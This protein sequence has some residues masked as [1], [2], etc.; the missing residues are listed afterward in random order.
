[1]HW[2]P[3]H[4]TGR[5]APTSSVDVDL[6]SVP[7]G[8]GIYGQEDRSVDF[9]VG[10]AL[11]YKVNAQTHQMQVFSNGKLLRTHP[12]HHRQAGLHHPLRASR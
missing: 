1:M 5:P 9:H 10:D 4:A 12:D 2:R 8:N 3:K 7:A 6:N 11:V